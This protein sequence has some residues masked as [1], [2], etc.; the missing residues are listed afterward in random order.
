MRTRAA[1]ALATLAAL[2]A[3]PLAAQGTCEVNNQA[4][5]VFGNDA[6]HAISV[7][8]TVAARLT[9]SATSLTL[10]SPGAASFD[11]GFGVPASVGLQVRANTSWSVTILAL[12]AL[13]AA[14]PGTARQ[15]KPASDL[16][17]SV[18]M[19]GP[20]TDL[21]TLGQSVISGVATGTAAPTLYL[22]AKYAW[23]MDAAGAYTLPVQLVLT[24]P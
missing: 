3:A 9:A 10:P 4:S 5:C 12:D 6:T 20:F 21:S 11:A 7:T 24:A 8:I 1:L 22:R 17:F 16:Q 19:E 2:V 23:A 18:A 14:T 15:D 13:W